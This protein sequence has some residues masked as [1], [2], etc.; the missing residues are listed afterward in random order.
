MPEF[1]RNIL[2][3]LPSGAQRELAPDELTRYLRDAYTK[4]LGEENR[5]RKI[6]KRL[7]LYNDAGEAQVKAVIKDVFTNLKT[8]ELREALV[9]YAMSQNLTRRI[10]NEKS[11]VYSELATRSVRSRNQ[12]YQRL[13]ADL[14]QDRRMRLLNRMVNLSNEVVLRPDIRN[15]G[16]P[17]LEIVT[18]DDFYAIAH[19]NRPTQLVGLI[20]DTPPRSTKEPTAPHYLVMGEKEFFQLDQNSR[21]V[22]GSWHEHSIGRLPAILV[23]QEEP[24]TKLLNFDRGSDLVSVHLAVALL[25][26][27]LIKHQRGGTRVP[28][29]TGDTSRVPRG[30]PMEEETVYEL[31]EGVQLNTLD[32]GANPQSYIDVAEYFISGVAA[33][34]GIPESVFKL[35]Y[36]GEAGVSLEMRRINLHE[37]RRD[38]IVDYRMVERELVDLQS[39]IF[40][41][42]G[43]AFGPEG[44]SID[45]GEVE[46]PQP[47]NE[48]LEDWK[49]LEKM[50]LANVIEMYMHMNPE[51]SEKEALAAVLRN[52]EMH[53]ERT[54]RWQ[55]AVPTA[56][57]PKQG[58]N[59]PPPKDGQREAAE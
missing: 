51:A 31:G 49:T 10:V 9:P 45:F 6:R 25:N 57:T 7:D 27:M 12:A 13:L 20:F 58:N 46:M 4:N 22:A 36:T 56:F 34:H 42:T 3:T 16:V 28:Y 5:K 24:R 17:V 47:L 29:A 32:L 18:Q 37:L 33:N 40:T 54:L 23:H 59:P 30:Q 21:M 39:R 52:E 1:L 26:V 38:Q 15:D 2:G 44:W 19:P 14:R 8:R 48:R 43:Y 41:G 35:S 55:S 11:T 53:L 50:G